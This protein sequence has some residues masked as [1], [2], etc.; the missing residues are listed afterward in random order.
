MDLWPEVLITLFIWPFVWEHDQ[1]HHPLAIMCFPSPLCPLLELWHTAMHRPTF[2]CFI[3]SKGLRLTPFITEHCSRQ[4][5]NRVKLFRHLGIQQSTVS[6]STSDVIQGGIIQH[7]ESSL[8][9]DLCHI[10][11]HTHPWLNSSC[12]ITLLI[13]H[14]TQPI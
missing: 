12:F 13:F 1:T 9:C 6:I 11:A 3:T 8:I 7:S 10:C 5:C 14:L 2:L 4:S